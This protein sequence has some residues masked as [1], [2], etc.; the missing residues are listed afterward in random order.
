MARRN[1]FGCISRGDSIFDVPVSDE[2]DEAE[3]FF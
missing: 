1:V 2:G 3:E